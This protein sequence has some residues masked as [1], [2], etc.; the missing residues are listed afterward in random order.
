MEALKKARKKLAKTFETLIQDKLVSPQEALHAF[1]L[2]LDFNIKFGK[3][4]DTIAEHL[5]NF[6]SSAVSISTHS[7]FS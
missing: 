2:T 4:I 3:G 1:A 5:E 7:P 6:C